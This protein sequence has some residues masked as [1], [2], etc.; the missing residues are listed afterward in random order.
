MCTLAPYQGSY[1]VQS[2]TAN[3]QGVDH[4]A[5][6][7]SAVIDPCQSANQ[8]VKTINS[9]GF[10]QHS[11]EDCVCESGFLSGGSCGLE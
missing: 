4:A 8:T 1:N 5:T 9:P 6:G 10:V 11:T 7:I 2:R 3:T